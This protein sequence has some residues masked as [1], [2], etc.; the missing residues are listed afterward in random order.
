[1]NFDGGVGEIA[2]RLAPL[3]ITQK[4][5]SAI[6]NLMKNIN[7]TLRLEVTYGA[8]LYKMT[9]FGQ[10]LLQVTLLLKILYSTHIS[11]T[12]GCA[13]ASSELST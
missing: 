6:K 4:D 13:Y 2:Q 12:H 10:M 11:S 8:G 3:S 1:M 7:L 5:R 9:Y